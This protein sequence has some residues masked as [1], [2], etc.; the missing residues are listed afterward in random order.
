MTNTQKKNT[1]FSVLVLMVVLAAFSRIIPH[2]PN[3]AP[4]GAMAIF[5]A[6]YFS[7]KV[8][9][10]LVPLL[11][12]WLS[13]LV[14]SNTIYAHYYTHFMWLTSDFY[15]V[16]GSFVL[17]TCLGFLTVKKVNL[18]TVTTS[19]I[20]A[21][22]LFFIVT[23]FGTW[24]EGIMYPHTITGLVACFGAGIPFFWNTLAGD[25]FYAGILFGGFEFAKSKLP[26]LAY[27]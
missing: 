21:A 19:G 9:A 25:L 5:G 7:K 22:I 3:F 18:L 2:L 14:I 20:A 26:V 12:L 10:F 11:S 6:A 24:A 4:I 17:I 27:N 23:N 16:Y 8:Y 15:W 1:R 13:D